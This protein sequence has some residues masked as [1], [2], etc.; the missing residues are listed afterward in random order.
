MTANEALQ[1]ALTLLNYR[2]HAADGGVPCGDG[3]YK[4]A[5]S[6]INQVAAELWYRDNDSPF[7]PLAALSEP[8]PLTEAVAQTVLPYGVAMLIAQTLGDMDNQTVYA[9]LYDA[10]RATA[11]QSERIADRL[12]EVCV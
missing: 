1:Q 11:R 8:L 2:D 3:V 10:R 9:A 7:V 12:P 5:L 6:L 4:N